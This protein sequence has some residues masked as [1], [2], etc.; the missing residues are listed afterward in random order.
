MGH[1]PKAPDLQLLEQ[2]LP[3]ELKTSTR[4]QIW[5]QLQEEQLRRRLQQDILR[6][7]WLAPPFS[8]S[9]FCHRFAL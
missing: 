4:A 9:D 7:G 1:V 2:A 8:E 5:V 6:L 3:A